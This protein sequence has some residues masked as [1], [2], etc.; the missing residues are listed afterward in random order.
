M[1]ALT[2][3]R[4]ST[5]KHLGMKQGRGTPRLS[6]VSGKE[7]SQLSPSRRCSRPG[8]CALEHISA[9]QTP[10]G[11]PRRQRVRMHGAVGDGV[12]VAA[13]FHLAIPVNDLTTSRNFYGELLG[14]PEGRSAATWVDFNLLGH[15]VVCHVV[16][17]YN[18][19]SSANAVDG[20][21]VPVPHF[22]MAMAVDQ[23]HELA[24]RLKDNG[25]EFIIDPHLRFEGMPGEQ[26]A[27]GIWGAPPVPKL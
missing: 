18:A 3:T 27:P 24:T 16:Q 4:A 14:C 22:G 17:G 6:I 26:V 1:Q 15:Q 23:F 5:S 11:I 10:K 9:F 25:V 12:N 7:C 19:S 8:P 13:P 21:P 20:D 2:F